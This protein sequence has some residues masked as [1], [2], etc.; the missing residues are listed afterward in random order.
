MNI[1]IF[2]ILPS[3][4]AL[5]D[6]WVLNLE[7]FIYN[8]KIQVSVTWHAL[9][10]LIHKEDNHASYFLQTVQFLVDNHLRSGS[11]EGRVEVVH[12]HGLG[13]GR[14]CGCNPGYGRV[15]RVSLHLLC[16][17]HPGNTQKNPRIL[18]ISSLWFP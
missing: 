12:P 2:S 9:S 16:R 1:Y 18:I 14:R 8:C 6:F 4:I 7:W 15:W 11:V 17:R 5:T 3:I 10:I 13:V